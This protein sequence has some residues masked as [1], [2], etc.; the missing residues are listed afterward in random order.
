MTA[1]KIDTDLLNRGLDQATAGGDDIH[2]AIGP[3]VEAVHERALMVPPAD[4]SGEVLKEIRHDVFTAFEFG[5][6][7]R[8]A[9]ELVLAEDPDDNR[10]LSRSMVPKAAQAIH[11]AMEAVKQRRAK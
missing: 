10:M 7:K 1:P 8:V 6:E 4:K 9:G 3:E 11:E 5:E 2:E